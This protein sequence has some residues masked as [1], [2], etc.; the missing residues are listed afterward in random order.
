MIDPKIRTLLALVECG[1]YTKTAKQLSLTQ[2]AIT[3]HIKLLEEEFGIKI[4]YKNRRQLVPTPEGE[5]CTAG[6]RA[7]RESAA[8]AKRCPQSGK[9][10]DAGHHADRPEQYRAAFVRQILQ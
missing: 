2:P 5:I 8:G 3:H 1:N 7:F 4:F 9:K 10:P 6:L